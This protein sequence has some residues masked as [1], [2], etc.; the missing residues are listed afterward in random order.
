MSKENSVGQKNSIF[1]VSTLIE[2]LDSMGMGVLATLIVGTILR[3]LATLLGDN[4]EIL[5][6]I[7]TYAQVFMAVGVAIGVS[8]A[9]K[10]RPVVMYAAVVTSMMGAGAFSIIDGVVSLR[11]GDPAAAFVTALVTVIVGSLIAGRTKLD[12]MLTPIISLV[13]GGLVAIHIAPWVTRLTS[14]IG[15]AVTTATEMHPIWMGIIV[16]VIFCFILLSPLSSSAL[17]IGLGLSGIAAGAALAGT[18]ACMVGFAVISF[19]DNG[20]GGLVSQGIGTAKIQFGN[21]VKNPVIFLP[22]MLASAITGPLSTVVF[23]METN[24]LG[25]GMGTS[26][27]VGQIQTLYVMGAD[28]LWMIVLVQV[29]LPILICLLV[30]K[31]LRRKNWINDG[32][33]V[34]P[35]G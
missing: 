35:K 20:I 16:S 19:K 29:V 6:T 17:A 26:G 21:F 23:R 12:I 30:W 34:L 2:A 32:D 11:V 10:V 7:G 22:V 4:F 18:A 15:V 28:A 27:L 8:S 9:L 31:W 5:F 13:A 33:M 1:T 25:A 3:Q 24:S 14:W